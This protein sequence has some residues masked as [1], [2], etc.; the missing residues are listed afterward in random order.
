MK[1]RLKSFKLWFLVAA[2]I[3]TF[4]GFMLYFST[5]AAFNY[6]QDRWVIALTIISLWGLVVLA[7]NA[8]VFAKPFRFEFFYVV[9]PFALVIAIGKLLIPCLSPIGIYFTVNMGDMETYA[10]G[11]PRCIAGVVFY[12]LGVILTIVASFF[13]FKKEVENHET[14]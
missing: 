11:V 5:F 7:I 10:I 13:S 1:T 14:R 9:I 6:S 3:M 2:I 8:L 12:L 4:V